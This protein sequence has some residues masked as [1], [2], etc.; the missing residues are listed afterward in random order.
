MS[1]ESITDDPAAAAI[2]AN[3]VRSDTHRAAPLI[4]GIDPGATG[5]LALLDP[6]TRDLWRWADMPVV[7]TASGKRQ[8]SAPMLAETLM[9][10]RTLAESAG[11]ASVAIVEEVGAMPGQGVTSMFSFGRSFGVILGVLAALNLPVELVRPAV[12][13]RRAGIGPDKGAARR[14]AQE[15]L[16]RRAELFSRVRDDGRAEAAL[17][18]LWRAE[19]RS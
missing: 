10:W 8:V 6:E 9:A 18:A 12:W 7:E 1:T 19:A 15:R 2:R 11:R 5:A 14:I 17:L 3:L 4:I 16:P 13:K